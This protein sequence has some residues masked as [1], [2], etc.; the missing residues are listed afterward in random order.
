[1]PPT[2][3]QPPQPSHT[4]TSTS[5]RS[6]PAWH[7]PGEE[8][9]VSEHGG[10]QGLEG[11]RKALG[12]SP[13][14]GEESGDPPLSPGEL[15]PGGLAQPRLK[16]CETLQEMVLCSKM[17]LLEEATSHLVE[18]L[19]LPL[20]QQH[21]LALHPTLRE[22]QEDSIEFRNICSHMALQ[23]VGQQFQKDLHEAHQCLKTIIEKLICS[24]ADFPPDSH[25]LV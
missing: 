18:Y 6:S 8:G 12:K 20:L 16:R 22:R 13:K 3:P 7:R 14:E 4:Q 2:P 25:I 24:L 19:L 23:R 1:S 21:P 9:E 15:R 17:S 5:S 11:E 10:A